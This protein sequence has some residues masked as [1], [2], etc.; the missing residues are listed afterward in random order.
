VA[1]VLVVPR[2]P[3]APFGVSMKATPTPATA[4]PRR[5]WVAATVAGC[6]GGSGAGS[7]RQQPFMPPEGDLVPREWSQQQAR[8]RHDDVASHPTPAASAEIAGAVI[9]RI[10]STDWSTG[11]RRDVMACLNMPPA[12]AGRKDP[13]RRPFPPIWGSER[14]GPGESGEPRPW[15][16]RPRPRGGLPGRGLTRPCEAWG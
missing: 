4:G 2:Y 10:T 8:R 15:N 3:S 7:I 6:C 14:A 16:E 11:R 13:S 5:S 12:G 1:W 9:I